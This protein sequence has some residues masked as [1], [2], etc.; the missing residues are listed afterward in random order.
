MT[1][2][3][4]RP[5]I[6]EIER[7]GLRDPDDGLGEGTVTGPEFGDGPAGRHVFEEVCSMGEEVYVFKHCR[8]EGL[9]NGFLSVQNGRRCGSLG[10]VGWERGL[11]K[12]G[13]QRVEAVRTGFG[14]RT[15]RPR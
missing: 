7:F 14:D 4:A 1:L 8:R 13:D 3:I 10:R 12:P 9:R 2:L 11:V 5:L 6:D 15:F